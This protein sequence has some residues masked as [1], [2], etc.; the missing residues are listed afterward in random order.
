MRVLGI[1]P[2]LRATGYGVIE[3]LEQ[4]YRLIALGVIKPGVRRPLYER[5]GE[6]KR[7]VDDLILTHRPDEIVVEN[8]FFA[9]NVKT[10]L[11]L[12]QV[13]GAILVAVA[14]S[15]R[16]L[17][18]YSPLEI[19]QAVTGFGKAGKDQVQH[20]VRTLLELDEKKMENDASD[21]LAAAICHA[22]ARRFHARIREE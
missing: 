16:E 3:D 17:F 15:R 13:R 9:R 18:E 6:I 22:N 21:A 4:G 1:D 7:G 2:S 5:I 10:A 14:E 20:M 12:G 19:K 11:I 8:P